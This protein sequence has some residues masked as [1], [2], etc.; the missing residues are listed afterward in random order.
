MMTPPAAIAPYPYADIA[1]AVDRA[2][3]RANDY[4]DP[5]ADADRSSGKYS[6]MSQDFVNGAWRH[7]DEGDL[8]QASNKAWGLVAETIKA[9][10]AEHGGIIHKHRSIMEVV[11]QLCQLVEDAGDAQTARQLGNSFNTARDLHT[12]FYENELSEYLVLKGLIDCEELSDR[13]FA[14]FWPAGAAPPPLAAE[15][16]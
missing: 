16:C 9:I 13:L 8:P 6:G 1:A 10:S 4:P 2:L 14:L 7:L 5:D 15:Q 12:N 3:R 11:T